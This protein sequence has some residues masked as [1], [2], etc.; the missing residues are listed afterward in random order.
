MNETQR[1]KHSPYEIKLENSE[2]AAELVE[3]NSAVAEFLK[4]L[5]THRLDAHALSYSRTSMG[6]MWTSKTNKVE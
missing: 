3:L 2:G 4:P 6:S 1:V 5:V